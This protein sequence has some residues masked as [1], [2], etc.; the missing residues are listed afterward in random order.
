MPITLPTGPNGV[1]VAARSVYGASRLMQAIQSTTQ[2][3]MNPS[4]CAHPNTIVSISNPGKTQKTSNPA[5]TTSSIHEIRFT[6]RKSGP[7]TGF[8][9]ESTFG[10]PAYARGVSAVRTIRSCSLACATEYPSPGLARVGR[11]T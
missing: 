11:P 1:R 10:P 9:R 4:P 2:R 7:G 8:L 3:T 5:K 6:Q